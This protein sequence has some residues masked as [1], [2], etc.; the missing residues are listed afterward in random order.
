MKKGNRKHVRLLAMAMSLAVV[1]MLAAFIALAAQPAPA[2][3]QDLCDGPLAPILP[4]CEDS[5]PPPPPSP[6]TP[7]P[8][9]DATPGTDLPAGA[10][11]ESSSTSAGA[12][13]KLT[14]TIVDLPN[15]LNSGSWVE[16]YLE[17]DYQ[18]PGSISRQDVV[19]IATNADGTLTKATNDG[20]TVTA[21]AVEIDDGGEIDGEDDAVVISA[22]IP[23]MDPRDDSFGYPVQGQTLIMIVDSSAG[24]KNP[25]EATSNSTGYAIVEAG[26]DRGDV[27]DA[28]LTDLLVKAKI[29]LSA[30]DGGRGKAVTVTGSGFNN[31]TEATVYVQPNAI[32]MWWDGLD[33]EMMNDAVSPKS[34]EPQVGSDDPEASPASPYCAMYADLTADAKSVVKRA[35][36]A[37]EDVC[38]QIVDDGDSLGT[39]GV[40]GD[41]RFYVEFTVHQD[42]FDAGEVNYICAADNESPSNR[43]A[44]AVKVFDV[45]PSLTISPDSVS[46][47]EEVTL[48]PRDFNDA[49]A[50][51]P[52]AVSLNGG[53]AFVPKADGSDYVFDMPGGLSG[54]VQVSFKQ[55]GDT[56][57]ETITV[58]PSSLTLN[59]TEVAPNQSI[60]ISGSG[61][62]EDSH[63][64]VEKIT[65]DGKML[66]VDDAGIEG[67]LEDRH[68]VTTSSGQFTVT[69]NIWHDGAGNPALD[70]DEYT[71]KVTDSNGYEG[72]TKIT[73]LEPT[74]MVMPLVAGPRDYITIRGANWPVTTSDDDHDVDITVDGKTR[75]ASIDST[76]RF[77]Y[78]YQL[79]GGIDI[80]MEHDIT[81]M[82]DGGTGGD[83]EETITFSVP[84]ANVVVTPPAAAPGESIGLEITGMPIYERVTEVTID[85]GNRLG[86]TAVN[87]NS[88]GDVSIT[89]IVIPF[90]DPGFYPVKIV[91]G[92]GGSAETAIVQLEIL[93][94]S[95]VR[96]VASQLPE[97]VTELGDSLVRIFHFNSTSK[98]WTFYDPRP[99]FESLNTLTELAAG[100]PYSILV[101]ETVE[102]VV[103]NGKIRNLTCVGGDCWNQE[104]W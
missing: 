9:T 68:V 99:E 53:T 44:S 76:G 43:L 39:D 56:K 29:G 13:V 98:V 10:M 69:V 22:R 26:D 12:S 74:V 16:I 83:I 71:I 60:I 7:P 88:E 5:T 27:A 45:T 17:D 92:T 80:G 2:S 14:L 36:L 57:R 1:G 52:L 6:G 50:E 64:L 28:K 63:V 34:D 15:N 97:A 82:F 104:V 33:C 87:T 85:G 31:G 46:S 42:E 8:P 4:Q 94:E 101:S 100:Q 84:S 47:G 54:V 41:D 91:V 3:A 95:G 96:G 77:N 19:F 58:D 70:A 23:D 25:T 38:Q 102:N 30:D 11:L 90:A 65:I 72:K 79:S 59:Q 66:A 49:T 67:T 61:F 75:S 32:A 40:G 35:G 51:E 55:G 93:S 62:S 86:G 73:I 89:G 103:L 24:I 48:K 37:S 18:E 20:G 21:A 81:V 78:S